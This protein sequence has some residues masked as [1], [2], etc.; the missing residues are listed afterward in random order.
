MEIQTVICASGRG[1]NFEAIHSAIE[2]NKIQN[3]KILGLITDR[4]KTPAAKFA[5][6]NKIEVKEVNFTS[7]PNRET[8]DTALLES[9]LEFSPDLVLALGYRRLFSLAIVKKFRKKIINIHPSLLPAFPGLHAQKQALDYGVH[10][11]GATVHFI[12]DGMDTGPILGQDAV[13]VLPKD[14]EESLSKRILEA[15][16]RLIVHSVRL[17]CMGK[18]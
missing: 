2:Q 14:T 12:D 10:I 4:K 5:K 16:H 8:F 15:E 13:Q 9:L 18:L 3:C 6:K 1:S 11:A 17:F 7:F